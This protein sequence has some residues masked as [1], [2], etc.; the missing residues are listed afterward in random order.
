MNA[1]YPPESQR[2]DLVGHLAELRRRIL[3]CLGFLAVT[4]VVLFSQGRA[5]LALL[6]GAAHGAVQDFIFITPTEAF[7]TY[8]KVV[9]VAAFIVCFPVLLYEFWAFIAPALVGTS[10]RAVFI[11]FALAV[12]C[13]LGGVVFAYAVLLPT[14]LDFLL[15]FAKGIARPA[16]A[17][18]HYVSFAVALILIGGCVFEIPVVLGILTEA[19]ILRSRDLRSGRRY[20]IFIIFFV[21][22]VVTPTQDA[23]NLILFAVPM[24]VL[25][26]VGILLSAGV[27]RR[28]RKAQT[29]EKS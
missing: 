6:Q 10:R 29:I 24:V 4:S 21:A 5:L 2:L 25:Y 20:A 26:E 8:L 11:W 13:F 1:L 27:E 19:R 23:F 12:I 7:T 18:S 15:N 22:A 3:I 14:A 9:V 16:I 28:R 17:I